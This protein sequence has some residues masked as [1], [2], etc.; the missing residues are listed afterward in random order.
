MDL[1]ASVFKIDAAQICTRIESFIKQNMLELN[2]DG[3]VVALSGG[4]DSSTVI[5]L[6]VRAL[7][8]AKVTALILPEKEGNPQATHY[9]TMM[10]CHLDIKTKIISLSKILKAAGTY[11]FILSKIPTRKLRTIMVKGVFK[12]AKENPFI[13]GL[14][15]VANT[16]YRKGKAVMNSKHRARLLTIYKYAEENNLLVAGCAHKSEDM[17]G[18]FVKFGVDDNADIMPLK[19]CYRSHILQIARYIKVP[20]EIIQRKPNPDIIPGVEDKY[21]DILGIDAHTIDIILYGIEN[22]LDNAVIARAAGLAKE[23]IQEI[24]EIVELTTHMRNPSM[25]PVL[26]L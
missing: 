10:A 15:G 20:D 2:R 16:M 26:D 21:Y 23:K 25:S 7:G 3:I 14:R 11:N 8:K 19:N 1:N 12:A 9:A 13:E 18:L 6:C 17:L 4:L 22:K 24:N 5:K